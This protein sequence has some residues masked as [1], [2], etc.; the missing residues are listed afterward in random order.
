MTRHRTHKARRDQIIQAAVACF[1]RKGYH[2][3]TMDDV[4]EEARLSKGALYW[5]FPS[6]RALFHQLVE[7]WFGDVVQHL[8]DLLAQDAPAGQKLRALIR[9]IQDNE[10]LRPELV[11]AQLEFYTVA[12]RDPEL[13]EWFRGLYRENVELLEQLI[14][15]GIRR[16][17]FRIVDPAAVARLF[18]A[19]LDGIVLQRHLVEPEASGGPDIEETAGTLF[20]LIEVKANGR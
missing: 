5:Y 1:A 14:R 3:T 20:A 15:E 10:A 17:E 12:A 7:Y 19:W 11:R 8:K 4:A 18:L 2:E 16:N 9:A 13:R 6:K